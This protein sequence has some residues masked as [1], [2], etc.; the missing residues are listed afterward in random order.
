MRMT[1]HDFTSVI[2]VNLNGVFFCSQE[3]FV[4]SMLKQKRGRIINISSIIGQIGRTSMPP[5]GTGMAFAQRIA[6]S[7]LATSMM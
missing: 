1:P 2:D 7:K 4:S 3:A 5:L 6:S